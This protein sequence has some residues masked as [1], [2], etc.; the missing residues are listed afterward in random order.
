M[1]YFIILTNSIDLGISYYLTIHL[2]FGLII[3]L[4]TTL[5]IFLFFG[6]ATILISGM[7][8]MP[9]EARALINQ[10]AIGKFTALILLYVNI[11]LILM[12]LDLGLLFT[13]YLWLTWVSTGL[14][15]IGLIPFMIVGIRNRDK[16]FS[17]KEL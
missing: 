2:T 17:K 5:M 8:L 4:L 1:K 3:V 12:W 7:M 11:T 14:M 6:K 13:Y 10:K 16:W 9:K 15:I